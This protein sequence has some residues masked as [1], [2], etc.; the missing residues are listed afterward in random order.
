MSSVNCSSKFSDLRRGS[1]V[2]L[3]Y[4]QWV[5]R[6]CSNLRLSRVLMWSGEFI[7]L[8]L[9]H[10]R[11]ML[12][13]VVSGRIELSSRIP[14]WCQRVGE[15]AEMGKNSHIFGIG[16]V[17]RKNN[18]LL[19]CHPIHL[20]CCGPNS[21]LCS[22]NA[23]LSVCLQVPVHVCVLGVGLAGLAFYCPV[24]AFACLPPCSK[25]LMK[26]ADTAGTSE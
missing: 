25:C 14:I 21:M 13:L 5:Q 4:S 22:R 20:A 17:E 12:T 10:G 26:A 6:T 15:L 7:G 8:S 3:I 11:S 19:P 1:W 23:C 24:V 9:Y 16:S 2:P 18:S